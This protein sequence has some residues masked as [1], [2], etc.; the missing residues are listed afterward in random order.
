[1]QIFIIDKKK[2]VIY[3]FKPRINSRNFKITSPIPCIEKLVLDLKA[4]II[5]RHDQDFYICVNMNSNLLVDILSKFDIKTK[6]FCVSMD[7][8]IKRKFGRDFWVIP[9]CYLLFFF[10]DFIRIVFFAKNDPEKYAGPGY[11]AVGEKIWFIVDLSFMI[12][13]FVNLSLIFLY[14]LDNNEWLININEYYNEMRDKELDLIFNQFSHRLLFFTKKLSLFV[15]IFLQILFFVIW[16]MKIDHIYEYPVN[17]M[18]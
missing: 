3:T 7:N 1:M 18:L 2:V 6:I 15:I 9:I 10:L 14:H 11:Y 13:G 16:C 8:Q 17:F 4:V 12:Y 5:L